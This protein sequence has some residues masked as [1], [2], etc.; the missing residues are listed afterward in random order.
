MSVP[1]RLPAHV[2]LAAIL[3]L[4]LPLRAAPVAD[5]APPVGVV[6]RYVLQGPGG[7]P[8]TDSD[9]RGRF[10]LIAFGYTYCP[11]VCPTTLVEMAHILKGL[12]SDAAR[13]QALFVSVDPERDTPALL[14]AYTGFFD[15]RI[16]GLTGS[17]QLLRRVAD[18]FKVRYEIVREPGAAPAQYAVDHSAG[19]YLLGPDGSFIVKFGYGA[20]ADDVAARIRSL[21][22]ETRPSPNHR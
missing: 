14:K 19:M 2:L 21:M 7:G 1:R 12:G 16:L 20:A 15:A 10:Q 9:F 17:P 3:C 22:A 4:S 13:L 5:D 8:V 6:P 18:L 11:D